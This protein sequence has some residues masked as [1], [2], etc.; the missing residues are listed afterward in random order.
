MRVAQMAKKQAMLAFAGTG[1]GCSCG[2]CGAPCKVDPIPG[3]EARMLKRSAKPKGLCVNCAV[4]DLL[5]HL[6]PANLIVARSGP[7]GLALPHMQKQFYEICRMAGTDA[8]FE[9]I[10]WSAII[11]NWD[12][13][14]PTRLKSTA[15][16]PVRQEELD[17]ARDEGEQ[18]R[19]GT[20]KEP[21][22]QEEYEA[23]RKAAEDRFIEC[24][25]RRL[26]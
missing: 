14:F 5:R 9:E 17:M 1:Q 6:Y 21:E 19:A 13:P 10:D 8:R 22:T 23:R 20:W 3:S 2:R 18:R 15:A 7:R 25:R 26:P 12:L 24:F 16:N 4:H 11:A